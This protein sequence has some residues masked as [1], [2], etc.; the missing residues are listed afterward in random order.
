MA[1]ITIILAIAAA[2]ALG[3]MSPGPSFIVVARL[4]LAHSRASGLAAA[5]GM[6]AG[7]FLFSLVALL[8]LTALLAAV[9]ILYLALKLG[10]GAYLIYLGVRLWRGA[11]DPFAFA[12]PGG[13]EATSIRRS[14][15]IGLATQFSNPKTAL[16]YAGV[17]T[18]FLPDRPSWI[19]LV[20]LPLVVVVIETGWYALVAVALSAPAPRGRYLRVKAWIDRAAGAVMSVLGLKLMVEAARS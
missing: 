8:G 11:R 2:L 3:A 10:G 4:A 16:V 13:R 15:W 5:A 20:A 12:K 1:T 17:F 9:P 14:F 7:G 19:L 18:A 6:G